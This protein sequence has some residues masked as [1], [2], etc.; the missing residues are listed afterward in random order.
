MRVCER[1]HERDSLPRKSTGPRSA[2]Q[3]SNSS[4]GR[5]GNLGEPEPSPIFPQGQS[6]PPAP[7]PSGALQSPRTQISA[8]QTPASQALLPNPSGYRFLFCSP[9]STKTHPIASRHPNLSH[10]VPGGPEPCPTEARPSLCS[11]L[12]GSTPISMAEASLRLG[13]ADDLGPGSAA[14]RPGG[15]SRAGD[16]LSGGITPGTAGNTQ[17]QT[18]REPPR[19]PTRCGGH[20]SH[21]L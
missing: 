19:I 11:V 9:Q 6:L 18:P 15:C 10:T 3:A 2:R 14:G 21:G 13:A 8:P 17:T 5:E 1:P 20:R 16:S 4:L 12:G 7:Q